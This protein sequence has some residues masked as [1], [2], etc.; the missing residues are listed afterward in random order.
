MKYTFVLTLLALFFVTNE[1]LAQHPRLA[2]HSYATRS[3]DAPVKKGKY[4]MDQ[5]IGRWQETSRAKSST[6]E[7]VEV[8][9]TI[10][11]HFYKNKM[12]QV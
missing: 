8:I 5:F 3:G 2:I 4:S 9:D 10:Y 12:Q 1:A 11:L 6:K 7:K